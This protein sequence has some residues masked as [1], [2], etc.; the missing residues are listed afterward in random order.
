VRIRIAVKSVPPRLTVH[1]AAGL[2]AASIAET[3]V[4]SQGTRL[5]IE[6]H[7]EA[8]VISVF[9]GVQNDPATIRISGYPVRLLSVVEGDTRH[10]AYAG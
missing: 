6:V 1:A 8:A 5:R 10:L 7:Q 4:E 9:A 2:A 3:A